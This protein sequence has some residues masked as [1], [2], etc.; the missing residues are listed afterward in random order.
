M[1]TLCE[2]GQTR[3][4]QLNIFEAVLRNLSQL[5]CSLEFEKE[6]KTMSELSAKKRNWGNKHICQPF[7]CFLH[8]SH[9]AENDNKNSTF[10]AFGQ[11]GTLPYIMKFKCP[12]RVNNISYSLSHYIEIINKIQSS[13]QEMC[14]I[15][16]Y[17]WQGPSSKCCLEWKF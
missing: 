17:G 11:Q 15:H 14:K 5:S 3:G 4:I 6:L 9:I 12:P 10:A 7:S 2:I 1:L 8:L 16:I 13:L